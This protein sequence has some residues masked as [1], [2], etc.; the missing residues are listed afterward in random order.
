VIYLVDDDLEAVRLL[1]AALTRSGFDVQAVESGEEALAEAEQKRP[2]AVVLETKL[3]GISGYTVCQEL[4]SRY[5]TELPVLFLSGTRTESY[6]RVAGLLVG[7]DDYLVKPF[8][9]DEVVARIRRFILPAGRARPV[10]RWNLTKREQEVL[11][12]LAAGRPEAEIAQELVISR[13]TVATHI[14]R[15]LGKLGVHSR[16]QAVALVYASALDGSNA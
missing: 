2:E 3:P 5:G 7:A 11:D 8:D 4:K 15:I 9:P 12:L 10:S 6:D 1:S 16:T 13:K 14:Q